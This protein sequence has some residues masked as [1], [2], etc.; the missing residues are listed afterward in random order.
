MKTNRKLEIEEKLEKLK[1]KSVMELVI[2][3]FLPEEISF[4]C[5]A[6]LI[7]LD[8]ISE[9]IDI[10]GNSKPNIDELEFVHNLCK[11]YHIDEQTL[12]ARIREVRDINK[13][14]KERNFKR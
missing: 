11:R 2:E 10:Y 4:I 1:V 5:R 3:G 14:I 12:T 6:I 8:E 13:L 7:P 9:Y